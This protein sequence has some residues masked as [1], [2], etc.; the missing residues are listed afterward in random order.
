MSIDA[1]LRS[2]AEAT[3]ELKPSP[4]T[5]LVEQENPARKSLFGAFQ[6][7]G[8]NVTLEDMQDVRR[9]MSQHFPREI[10]E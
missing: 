4:K 1:L 5:A 10:P 7:M 3:E 2:L 9:E 6:H 8:L